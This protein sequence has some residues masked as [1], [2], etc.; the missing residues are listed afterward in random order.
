M[1]DSIVLKNGGVLI[2]PT[3]TIWGIG[4]D[5]LNTNAIERVKN[6]KG[7]NNSK[8][9]IILVKDI[10]MLENYVVSIPPKAKELLEK[11]LTPTTIIYPKAKNLPIKQ[12]SFNESIG[13]RIPKSDYLQEVFKEFNH[14]IVST[15]ANFS[16]CASPTNFHDIDPLLLS[17]VDYVSTYNR[18]INN[19]STGSSIYLIDKDN[20]ITQLR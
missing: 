17:Q 1:Q 7:R 20:N 18:D 2:Y 19:N 15:S 14:P 16:G 11:T 6:I 9:L 8:S 5:A 3:D 10:E 4:C 13:I 12:L